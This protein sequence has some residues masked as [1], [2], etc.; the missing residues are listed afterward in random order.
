MEFF[1]DG[2]MSAEVI[3]VL[4]AH[5]ARSREHY[6]TTL[7]RASE[8]HSGACTAKSTIYTAN[9]SAGLMISQFTKWLRNLPSSN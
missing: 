5:D 6:P 3:R 9:I 7:F 4:S 8:A 2:R 1:S